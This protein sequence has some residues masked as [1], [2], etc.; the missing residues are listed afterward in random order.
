MSLGAPHN[1]QTPILGQLFERSPGRDAGIG[2]AIGWI[3][4]VTTDRT[5][6][7]L[8]RFLL[9][10]EFWLCGASSIRTIDQNFKK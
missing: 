5:F 7:L 1:G 6:P 4:D 10:I 8:H 3:V 2:I 9:W